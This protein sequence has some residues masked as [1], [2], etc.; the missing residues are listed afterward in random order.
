METVTGTYCLNREIEGET[1]SLQQILALL[2][3][4]DAREEELSRRNSGD[5]TLCVHDGEADCAR[6]TS[7]AFHIGDAD[8]CLRQA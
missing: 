8:R 4:D 1:Y 2:R 7:N 6:R 5:T 3:G